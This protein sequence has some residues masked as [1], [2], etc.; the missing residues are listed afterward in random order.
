MP[1]FT[2][3]ITDHRLHFSTERWEAL[4]D[5]PR[6]LTLTDKGTGTVLVDRTSC[7]DVPPLE[8]V[9]QSGR[10]LP[11]GGPAAQVEVIRTGPRAADVVVVEWEAEA[12]L[13]LALDPDTDELLVT[14]SLSSARRGV[15]GV[16]WNLVGIAPALELVAPLFQGLRLP[17]AD[18]LITGRHYRWPVQWE[19][20]LA[21]LQGPAGG[22]SVHTQDSRFRFKSLKIG[23][24]ATPHALGFD[25]E[26]YGPWDRNQA[27]GGLTW[28]L[29][30]HAGDW[31]VAAGRYRAWLWRT[32][33]LGEALARRP[34]WVSKV[35]LALSWC[36][37]DVALLEA[38]A[39]WNP[40]ERTLLHVPNW[41]SD[42]YDE[43]YPTYEASETGA[44]FINQAQL[45][46]FRVMP[47]FNAFAVDPNHPAFFSLRDFQYRHPADRSL[48]GW[49][50]DGR[51]LGFPQAPALQRDQ[52]ARKV[53][54]YIHPGL[55]RWR[56]MLTA[57]IRAAAEAL[58]LDA[59]FVDQTLCAWNL[60]NAL[61][62]DV[63]P[64]EGMAQLIRELVEAGLSVSGEGLN[65]ITMQEQ[66]F[67]QAHLFHSHHTTLEGLERVPCPV[68]AFLFEGLC[69]P[70]GYSGLH[71]RDEES[72]LRLRVHA[73]L[74]AIPTLTV[75]SAEEIRQP[76]PVVRSVLESL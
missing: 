54:A 39:R 61:V 58:H 7:P 70:I 69:R 17:L 32:Y 19:A 5:G 33:R 35:N 50:W 56:Q 18:G 59:V 60:D 64:V 74:G 40:P 44:E 27:A 2:L 16:R 29:H 51:Y 75:H 67:A 72:A 28:R 37:C 42:P 6:L 63:T 21:I 48:E 10:T 11:L 57:R 41:R 71:G 24:E 30:V 62:E 46:G 66:S 38:L 12:V 25:T 8:L 52:R 23:T 55:T 53:M 76:N 15:A 34:A 43:N 9:H 3:D 65:E 68:N 45:L 26:S 49:S 36:P 4:W 14:P 31:T 73:A 22:F 13:R 20:A 1:L 47:H